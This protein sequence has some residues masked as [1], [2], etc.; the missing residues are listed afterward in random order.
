MRTNS[1]HFSKFSDSLSLAI[2]FK[3][4][5][6]STLKIKIGTVVSKYNI[7][8]L[9]EMASLLSI[10]NVDNWK[11]YRIRKRGKGKVFFKKNQVPDKVV[12]QQISKIKNEYKSLNIYYSSDKITLDSHIIIDPDSTTYVINGNSKK[13]FGKLFIENKMFNK[14]IWQKI[15]EYANLQMNAYNIKHSFPGWIN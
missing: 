5:N 2:D 1:R 3:N 9:E 4:K 11:L 7:N 13:K 8:E 14:E 6:K 10:K 15:I 12:L